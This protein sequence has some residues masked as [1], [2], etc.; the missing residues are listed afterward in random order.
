MYFVCLKSDPVDRGCVSRLKRVPER[1][2]SLQTDKRCAQ[3]FGDPSVALNDPNS[4]HIN[5]FSFHFVVNC[6][7]P[8]RIPNEFRRSSTAAAKTQQNGQTIFGPRSNRRRILISS[9]KFAHIPLLQRLP[10]AALRSAQPSASA[11][12]S[13]SAK[14]NRQSYHYNR[15]QSHPSLRRA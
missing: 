14:R 6:S 10:P 5:S 2:L 12:P 4:R 3:T 13:I 11:C 8:P 7:I 1:I 15:T 9:I